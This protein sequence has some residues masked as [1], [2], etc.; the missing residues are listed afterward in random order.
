MQGPE[1][2]ILKRLKTRFCIN[3][4]LTFQ[5]NLLKRTDSLSRKMYINIKKLVALL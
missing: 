1:A 2:I 4:L 3:I 5:I